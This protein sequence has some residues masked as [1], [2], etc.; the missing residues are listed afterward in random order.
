[1]MVRRTLVL[2]LEIVGGLVAGIAVLLGLF[3]WR[4]SQGPVSLD[5]LEPMLRAEVER[6]GDGQGVRLR[7]GEIVLTWEGL[8]RPLE[9]RAR[10]LTADAGAGD[11]P[12][13]VGRIVTV[14]EMGVSLDLQALLRGSVSPTEM[15]LVRPTIFLTRLEDGSL[16]LDVRPTAQTADEGASLGA[17]LVQAILAPPDPATPFGR[18]SLLR[19]VDARV[20]ID[21]LR[22]DR[23]WETIGSDLTLRREGEGVTLEAAMTLSAGAAATT[24]S[25]DVSRSYRTGVSRSVLRLGAIGLRDLAAV[26]PELGPIGRLGWTVAG[27]LEVDFAQDF[28]VLGARAT[29]ERSDGEGRLVASAGPPSA[30]G[31]RHLDVW[32]E[33]VSLA[34]LAP[35]LADPALLRDAAIT[36]DAEARARVDAAG[37]PSSARL[38]IRGGEGV[39]ALPAFDVPP[40][41]IRSL[42]VAGSVDFAT[43]SL[44][45]ETAEADLGGPRISAT[46]TAVLSPADGTIAVE[47]RASLAGMPV[48]D[49]ALRW[50]RPVVPNARDWIVS[51][52]KGGVIDTFAV[53][54]AGRLLLPSD[55]AVVDRFEGT[56]EFRDASV[57]YL[58]PMPP[59]TGV[60]GVATVGLSRADV[61]TLAGARLG[62]V[63]VGPARIAILGLDEWLQRA[64]I[65]IPVQGPVRSMLQVLDGPPL[66]LMRRIELSPPRVAGTGR[67]TLRIGFPLLMDLPA[68][69]VAVSVEG[70][71]EGGRIAA[72]APGI[73]M[74][75]GR[76]KVAVTQREMSLEGPVR[77]NGVPVEARW[78]ERFSGPEPR[79]RVALRGNLDEAARRRLP[80]PEL[81]MVRG[82]VPA[83]LDLVSR[84]NRRQRITATLD[85]TPAEASLEAL[86]WR[87]RPGERASARFSADVEG[88]RILGMTLDRLEG[89]GFAASARFVFAPGTDELRRIDLLDL[90]AEG[91][92]VAG[93]ADR[94]GNGWRINLTGS[95]VDLRRVVRDRLAA[96]STDDGGEDPPV[97]LTLEFGRVRVADGVTLTSVLGRLAFRDGRLTDGD[98]AATA[99]GGR[100]RAEVRPDGAASRFRIETTDLG[101][102]LAGL[103]VAGR[104]R[105]GTATIEGRRDPPATG[106]RIA[107]RI[108]ATGF[109]IVR[110]PTMVR[111]FNALSLGGLA[112]LLGNDG[113]SIDRLTADF[114]HEA[115]ILRIGN[116]RMWG[117]QLGLTAQGSVDTTADRIEVEGTVVPLYGIN[118]VIGAIPLLGTL[119]TGGDGQGLLAANWTLRGPLADPQLGVNPLSLFAP[120]LL[121]RLLFPTSPPVLAEEPR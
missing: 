91:T 58:R 115:P 32:A 119:L 96:T 40:T 77:L 93:T 61:S 19:I 121:R 68:D 54:V 116:A 9:I 38:T 52:I 79:T 78:Q 49:L 46:A 86:A 65:Q 11:A 95:D 59:V 99:E 1:M 56:I 25:L 76:L 4:L 75:E 15:E 16:Q 28:A 82:P 21:D 34:A 33:R 31:G 14:P 111:L 69:D 12:R 108:E 18:L 60:S 48:D 89:P 106:G 7:V 47:A 5:F 87:K 55:E 42:L 27:R 97:A 66:D 109:H 103:D 85:L 100:L 35:L 88:D 64:E 44:R 13:P 81:P 113:I 24:I 17:A 71:I 92:T 30:D 102:A 57:H 41:P 63:A 53:D 70:T 45:I 84:G 107:G 117:G 3:F 120:G 73:D 43:Q 94:Q 26:A 104:V 62:D 20:V 74:T 110:M 2:V 29:L 37:L 67:A 114:V 22:A 8:A 23:T 51:N 80:I 72:V 105:G 101:R 118:R 6:Q 90:S 39:V 112:D 36:V 83:R 10:R 50:P 98:L